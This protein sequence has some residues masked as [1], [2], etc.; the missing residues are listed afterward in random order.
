MIAASFGLVAMVVVALGFLTA[1]QLAAVYRAEAAGD[2]AAYRASLDRRGDATA[3]VLASSLV[4]LL[5]SNQD[6]EIASLAAR[7]ARADDS[8]AALYVLDREQHVIASCAATACTP[9]PRAAHALLTEP[10]WEQVRATWRDRVARG[11]PGASVAVDATVVGRAVALFVVP[12]F[13]RDDVTPAAAAA[14]RPDDDRYGYLALAYDLAPLARLQA[15]AASHQAT[16]TAHA[17]HRAALVG[18]ACLALGGLLA[19][20][21]GLRLARPIRTL[22]TQADRIAAGDLDVAVT[23]DRRDE[24]GRLAASF[25][26]M[27]TAVRE[28]DA[29]LRAHNEQLEDAVRERTRAIAV[30]L[31]TTGDGLIPVALDGTIAG[32]VSAPARA[33]FGAPAPGA[34]AWDYLYPGVDDARARAWFRAAFEQVADGLL[35]FEL[36]A[37]QLARR[38]ERDGR[39]LA[40]TVR[41]VSEDE[42]RARLLIIARDVTAQVAAE[43][44]EDDARE[45]AEAVA[46]LLRDRRG[47]DRLVREIDEHL[48]AAATGDDAIRRRAL[49]TAKGSAACL[50]LRR[51]AAAIH[52]AEDRLDAEPAAAVAAVTARWRHLRDELRPY[53]GEGT[54]VVVVSAPEHAAVVARLERGAD[55]RAVASTVRAWA[56]EPVRALLEQAA[57]H[58]RDLAGRRGKQVEI[59]IEADGVRVDVATAA[60]LSTALVH[61]VRNAVDHGVEAPAVRVEHGKPA[62]GAVRLRARRGTGVVEVSCADDGAGIDWAAVRARADARGLAT[63]DAH[64]PDA[65][66]ADGLSTAAEVTDSSGRGVGL[67][68]ARAA[69][70][71]RGGELQVASVAGRGTTF[72]MR[73]RADHASAA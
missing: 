19:V 55:P 72:A 13:G 26:T 16:A 7:T 65:L 11:Q 48:A 46:A 53:T 9:T 3:A 67:A 14:D 31:D 66:F 59:T 27:A 36:A 56:D 12:V 32:D 49:H 37:A 21:Q 57:D 24:V 52:A 18:L 54:G 10:W 63:D 73:L 39:V 61:L 41:Q 28:R 20:V 17:V 33:W 58:A 29:T 25:A 22:A 6:A 69:C 50:G 5:V 23:V 35:P 44:A 38:L 42:H 43:R 1:R 62:A 64:L 71:A 47:F 34:A 30:L 40:V 60:A 4:P 70:R 51:L 45:L 8:L 2:T 68:A 15:E